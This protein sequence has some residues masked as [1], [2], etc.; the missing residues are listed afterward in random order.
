MVSIVQELTEKIETL[1]K[2]LTV[3]YGYKAW[4]FTRV[5]VHIES[6]FEMSLPH[7][8]LTRQV[9]DDPQ[10]DERSV[11]EW[12]LAVG[13]QQPWSEREVHL[14]LPLCWISPI[15]ARRPPLPTSLRRHTAVDLLYHHARIGSNF[16]LVRQ[17]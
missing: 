13:T 9:S 10:Q 15:L 12:H 1:I 8:R 16:K 17:T 7:L 11:S 3:R 4:L 5:S 2:K 14:Y 6:L